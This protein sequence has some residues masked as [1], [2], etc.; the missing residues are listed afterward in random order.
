MN[1]EYYENIYKL[2]GWERLG[3]SKN[4][5]SVVGKYTNDLIYERLAPGLK[6]EFGRRNPKDGKG[7]RKSKRHQWFDE[8]EE[9]LYAQQMFTVLTIQRPCLKKRG[10]KWAHF[11]SMMD[12]GRSFAKKRRYI[13]LGI[14]ATLFPTAY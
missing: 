13:T 12:D 8:A 2:K 1:L 5:Y 10:D 3:M 14:L 6:D 4:R 11:K 7:N 9:K